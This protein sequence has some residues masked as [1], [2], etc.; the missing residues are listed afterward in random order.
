MKVKLSNNIMHQYLDALVPLL[1]LKGVVGYA[2]AR[3]YRILKDAATE[4]L[5]MNQ[6]LIMKY[7]APIEDEQG[8]GYR[9]A[10]GDEN[11]DKYVS[12]ITPLATIEHEVDLFT[13]TYQQAMEHLTG[14][15][16]L[17]VEFM[18]IDATEQE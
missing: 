17:N 1:E 10:P 14:Q 18:L 8:Q 12:E 3:N 15:Q 4:Y 6:E 13:I 2:A 11:W 16:L 7:G 5:T 9:V